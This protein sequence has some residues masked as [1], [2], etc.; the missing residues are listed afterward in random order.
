MSGG[1]LW[2]REHLRP[3]DLP[4]LQEVLGACDRS[5][6]RR[7]IIEDFAEVHAC[8]DKARRNAMA[9]RL[10]GSLDAMASLEVRR[11]P[12]RGWVLAPRESYVLDARGGTLTWRLHAALVPLLNVAAAERLVR[13]A[14]MPATTYAQARKVDKRLR[15]LAVRAADVKGSAGDVDDW[16]ERCYA[17]A[18]WEETLGCKVWL[19]GD[20]CCRE[21]YRVLASAFWELTFYGF[22][23]DLVR[24]RTAREK[25]A[26]LMGGSDPTGEEA[27]A[28]ITAS[29]GGLAAAC[30]LQPPDRFT[31]E[32]L[33]RLAQR[34]AVLNHRAHCAFFEQM[35][36]LARRMERG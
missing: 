27:G 25:A 2:E 1:S 14:Q 23:Y 31:G 33:G 8:A 32:A 26:R 19:G 16:G 9:Q 24:A 6:L 28:R 21:R 12:T 35:L 34:V 36:D 18:P 22:E 11:G 30:G 7:V 15:S 20:W 13:V 29:P 10:D 5:L 4:S 3:R 17:L